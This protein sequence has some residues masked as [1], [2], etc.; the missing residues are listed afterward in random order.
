MNEIISQALVIAKKD[1]RKCY[2]NKGILTGSR[3]VYWSWDSFYAS[4]G[5]L[6]IGDYKIVKKNLLLYLNK[7][8]KNGNIPKR[9]AN[10][11]YPLKYIGL[12]I[13]EQ[14]S[15]QKPSYAS[16]YYTGTS[17]SQCPV[18]IIALHS[19]L[20]KTDDWDF[21][22]RHKLKLIRILDFL[23]SQRYNS[24]L[25]KESL[26]GGW[27][28]SILK[29]G[30]VTY[31]NICYLYSLKL[32]AEIFFKI[33]EKLLSQRYLE[34]YEKVKEIVNNKLWVDDKYGHYRDWHGTTYHNQFSSDGN[35]L[36]AIWDIADNKQVEQINKHLDE[37][38]K[39]SDPP[40][41]ASLGKY[42]YLR[43]F[44]VNRLGG[45]KNYH[46][47]FSWLWLGA[48]AALFKYK[49]GKTRESIKILEDI[50]KTIVKY[51]SVY[52]IYNNGKPVR[53]LFYK[54]EKPWAWS[55]GIFIYACHKVLKKNDSKYY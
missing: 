45:I 40:L 9:I 39:I 3:N 48:I 24:G 33:D 15:K 37:A 5:S 46:I 21:A 38:L 23:H 47:E 6:E 55:A 2:S 36:A 30:A 16:P 13:S 11:F 54:S 52:E 43:V 18:L 8:H 35:L 7:Q 20:T 12:P 28:E 10:P 49:I 14:H 22:R 44:I 31:T 26:G 19:Y 34:E 32:V 42:N 41:V 50:S 4:L 29:R 53:T 17:I 25:I 27:A 1:L 51:G